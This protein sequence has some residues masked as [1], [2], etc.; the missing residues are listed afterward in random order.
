MKN[1]D[2][3]KIFNILHEHFGESKWWPA[4]TPFEVMI[5]AI[6]TQQTNWENVEKSIENLKK[7]SLMEIDSLA[8]ADLNEI[9]DCI[10]RS[11]FFR[12]KAKRIKG[13]AEHIHNYY[14]GKLEKLFKKEIEDLRNELLSL[15][16]VGFET[17]DSILLYADSKP[18][19]VIDSYTFRIFKRLGIDFKDKY[20]IAQEYF[21]SRL[22]R[23]VKLYREY[24]AH[25][26]DLG[27]G[28]CKPRPI[29]EKCPLNPVC[30]YHLNL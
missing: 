27:K 3:K 8:K 30:K 17:A 12:Q 6:L 25:M 29:C 11:G 14:D 9:E 16:G 21:E 10:R 20:K 22:P 13:L 7:A 28:F 5:G 15:E 1:P 23:D 19:F 18:K 2:A 24:H 4:E 26:V